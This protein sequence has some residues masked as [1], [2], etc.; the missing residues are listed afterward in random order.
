VDEQGWWDRVL[1]GKGE[2]GG[3]YRGVVDFVGA[4]VRWVLTCDKCA[5]SCLV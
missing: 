4:N 3:C 1:Q 5:F 2:E